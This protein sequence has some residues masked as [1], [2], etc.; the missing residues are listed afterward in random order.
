MNQ[1]TFFLSILFFF[2]LSSPPWAQERLKL[3][4][5]TSTANSGLL[6]HLHPYFEKEAGIRVH[7]IAVGTGKAL[8]LA[9]NG[10]VDVVLVHARQ[11]EE[12]FVKAGH[13]VNRKEVMYND[14]VIVGPVTDPSGII[15]SENVIQALRTI[16]AQKSLWY[17]RGDDSGTHKKEMSLWQ[18][19]G[20]NPGGRW[21]QAVGQGM[22]KT[23]LAADEKK[24]YTLSDRGT[25]IALSTENR[26]ELKILHEGDSRL[27]NPYGVIAVNPKKHPH[28]KFELAMKYI[29]FLT[30]PRGQSL[31]G[32]FRMNGKIL[33]HPHHGG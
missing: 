26:I 22:G 3:A 17:S 9:Q 25:Y 23:L 7:A 12:A 20:L 33:F 24:A 10:D 2:C 27:F 18:E 5:T 8:K 16:A 1:A 29:D 32:S 28:V 15:G 11:A 14:F 13:G 21:F 31:I 30:S 4:T 6:D 19:T